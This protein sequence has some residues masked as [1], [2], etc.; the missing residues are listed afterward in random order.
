MNGDVVQVMAAAS[1]GRQEWLVLGLRWA[2]VS[3]GLDH[4]GPQL[5]SWR[6]DVSSWGSQ[7]GA[8]GVTTGLWSGVCWGSGAAGILCLAVP[9]AMEGAVGL[10]PARLLGFCI[11]LLVGGGEGE[12]KKKKACL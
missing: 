9:Q 11:D 6:R 8:G 1:L 2:V 4:G 5:C 12:K 3:T 7:A 10:P